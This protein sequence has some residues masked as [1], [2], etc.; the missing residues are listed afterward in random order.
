MNH[1]TLGLKSVTTSILL[2]FPED[3]S[4]IL[5]SFKPHQSCT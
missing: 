3:P 4:K 2:K 1:L 5:I